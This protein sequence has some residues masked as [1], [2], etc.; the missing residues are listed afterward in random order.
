MFALELHLISNSLGSDG[1][2]PLLNTAIPCSFSLAGTTL[3]PLKGRDALTQAEELGT[4]RTLSL[5]RDGVGLCWCS[6]G[7]V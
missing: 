2:K 5:T 7:L 3:F 4:S 1:T 6:F